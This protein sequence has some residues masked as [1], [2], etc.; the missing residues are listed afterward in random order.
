MHTERRHG[1]GDDTNTGSLL[2]ALLN[3]GD[4]LMATVNDVKAQV[5]DLNA[6][7]DSIAAQVQVL[8]DAAA[9]GAG[10]ISQAD[11]D[12]ISTELG[13]VAEKLTAI[14]VAAQFPR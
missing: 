2:R 10:N 7:A 11:F 4:L 5:A 12:G 6:K 13:H 1:G 8:Q 14:G 3:Q 9:G